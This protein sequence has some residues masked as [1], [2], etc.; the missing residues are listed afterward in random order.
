VTPSSIPPDPHDRFIDHCL[1]GAHDSGGGRAKILNPFTETL[2]AMSPDERTGFIIRCLQRARS[3]LDDI[4]PKNGRNDWDMSVYGLFV[5]WCVHRPLSRNPRLIATLIR[6]ATEIRNLLGTNAVAAIEHIASLMHELPPDSEVARAVRETKFHIPE[7]L[8]HPLSRPAAIE[9]TL[10]DLVREAR[11]YDGYEH[12][13]FEALPAA[14]SLRAAP[15]PLHAA[16]VCAAAHRLTAETSAMPN[17]LSNLGWEPE[18]NRVYKALVAVIAGLLPGK[19]ADQPDR[20]AELCQWSITNPVLPIGQSRIDDGILMAVKAACGRNQARPALAAWLRICRDRMLEFPKQDQRRLLIVARLLGERPF[21]QLDRGE[22]WSDQAIEDIDALDEPAREAWTQLIQLA[23]TTTS[24]KPSGKWL[25]SAA[26]CIDTIGRDSF[27]ASLLRWFP[28][29]ENPRTTDA[30]MDILKCLCWLASA[31]ADADMARALARLAISA[32][33]KVP[34]VGPRAVKVGNAAVYAL[35]EMKGMHAVGQLA[36]LRV[37]V[38]FGSAQ[39]G[40]EKALTAAAAREGLPRDEIEELGVPTYGLTGIGTCTEDFGDYTADLVVTGIGDTELRFTK[41]AVDGKPAKPQKSIPASVKA[42][43]AEELKELKGAAKD[44]ASML[45]A[46]R[47]RIDSLYL[48]NKPWPL[49]TWRERYLDH[50]LIGIIARR[51]IWSITAPGGSPTAAIWL[52]DANQ[53]VDV[54]GNAVALVGNATVRLWHPIDSTT[55]EVLAWRRFTEERRIKQPF[56]QAHREIYLLTDAER[57]TGTYSNRFAAHIIRQHQFHALAAARGWKNKLRLMVDDEYPPASKNLRSWGLRAEF[58]IE[59]AGEE[60]ND[61]SVYTFLVTDQ[62]RFYKEGAAQATAHAGG[63][64]YGSYHNEDITGLP[65]T[66]IPP[67][68][69]SE[70][71]RDVDLFVGVASVGNNPQW[72]D[73]GPGGAH[74][75]YWQAYSFGDLSA[76]GLGRRDLLQRLIPRLKIAPLCSF[77]GNFL[78]VQGNR[79]TY[80]IHLGSGN[81]MMKPNDQYLCIVPTARDAADRSDVF[82]PFEGD[83]TLSIILSKAFMLAEDDKIK[84]PSIVSQIGKG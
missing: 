9:A 15:Q 51:L 19:L 12:N 84:D 11:S 47:D 7:A 30:Q 48:E 27:F 70:V 28:L 23:R 14:E 46:Q 31:H 41:K 66:G 64:G 49:A 79:R 63:G 45:P 17:G 1:D 73:G 69:F 81:I 71:M 44:I 76:T 21:L 54:R 20:L 55:D 77:S 26:A 74:R 83:R 10:D 58:W 4:A 57:N 68:V 16:F 75:D 39:K 3:R 65:V 18:N 29:I 38:K 8:L 56:K 50:P 52:D 60:I 37:K 33:R 62:V 24:A 25:K 43:H 82:L 13:V 40:I 35:G 6:A 42:S 67:L 32:Y 61:A 2:T 22:A 72:N 53:L 78:V 34:G 59:G 5:E 36:M 80:K